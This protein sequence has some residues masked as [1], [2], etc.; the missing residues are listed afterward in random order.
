M[1]A[2]FQLP[3]NPL[4]C[5]FELRS[6]PSD[7]LLEMRIHTG[8]SLRI[9]TTFGVRYFFH[10]HRYRLR[11][12]FYVHYI[13]SPDLGDRRVSITDRW[14]SGPE[15]FD[16]RHAEPPVQTWKNKAAA[17]PAL[18]SFSDEELGR[19]GRLDAESAS[20]TGC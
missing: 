19:I 13:R 12:V 7:K 3:I 17:F 5:L 1:L 18:E 9:L 4:K 2:L 15:E 8:L 11:V 14:L 6:I 20:S 16:N 10:R